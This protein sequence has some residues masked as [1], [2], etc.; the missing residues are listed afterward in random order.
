MRLIPK[1]APLALLAFTCFGQSDSD[2]N[3]GNTI[4]SDAEGNSSLQQSSLAKPS[5]SQFFPLW[6][7]PA[8][9]AVPRQI[10]ARA[11]DH[12]KPRPRMEGS[13]TGYIE[14]A[15]VGNQIRLRFDAAFGFQDPDRAE[16]FY[17][18]C[19]CYRS[20]N[21]TDPEYDP[22]APGPGAGIAMKLNFQEVHLNVEYAPLPRLSFFADVPERSIEFTSV[23]SGTLKNASGLG[24]F[25]AGFK[26]A[27]LASPERYLTFE[28]GA[29]MPTGHPSLGLS[30]NHFSVE[31]LLLYN[32]KLSDHVTIAGQ[33]GDWHPVGGSAGLPTSS[34]NGFAG[35][36]LTYGLGASY[37]F[38]SG[39]DNHVTPVLEFVGWS[40][41]SG[42]ATG[43]GPASGTNIVN[44]KLGVRFSIHN[45]NSIYVGFGHALTNA[46]WYEEILRLEYRYAF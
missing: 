11:E 35:D 1:I 26:A 45:H 6:R 18:K 19:G 24:D 23:T 8:F 34:P 22:N 12:T 36:V 40:V 31:P 21:K 7:A 37:D 43:P 14:N 15:I 9:A 20:L 32:Q 41:L 27:L 10:Q 33:F 46:H 2:S 29:F 25:E 39:S 16:F 38:V 4:E 17:A 30:T 13:A 3:Q 5:V 28:M 42:F 44:A